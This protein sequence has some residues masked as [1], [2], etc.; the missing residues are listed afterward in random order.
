M[1]P[2]DKDGKQLCWDFSTHVGCQQSAGSCPRSRRQITT[3]AGLA[4]EVMAQLIRRGGLR[5]GPPVPP[6]EID[7]R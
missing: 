1:A 2:K 6:G 4:W 3:T 5:T 7:A